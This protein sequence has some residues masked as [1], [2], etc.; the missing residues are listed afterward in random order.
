[1]SQHIMLPK[2][3]QPKLY[4]KQLTGRDRSRIMSVCIEQDKILESELAREPSVLQSV[5]NAH[6]EVIAPL[7]RG[8][9]NQL[10]ESGKPLAFDPADLDRC[11]D[12][13][14]MME[15]RVA[16]PIKSMNDAADRKK[17]ASALL[18][19]SKPVVLDVLETAVA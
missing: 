12:D 11:I 8:W 18:S 17:S 15:L 2:C 19:S 4:F 1:M 13:A 3:D 5:M 6:Y 7:L 10:D 16:L 14:D 9:E